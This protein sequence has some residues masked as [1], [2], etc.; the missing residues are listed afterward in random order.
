DSRGDMTLRP[1]PRW[2][3]RLGWSERAWQLDLLAQSHAGVQQ[4]ELAARR[5]LE[6]GWWLRASLAARTPAPALAAGN[7]WFSL[8]LASGNARPGE[9]RAL[10]AAVRLSL[11][12]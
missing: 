7:D 6:S 12:F 11:P 1:R 9:A 2:T 4:L 10:S 8:A 5:G 3:A